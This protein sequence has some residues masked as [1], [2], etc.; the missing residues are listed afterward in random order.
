MIYLDQLKDF[1]VYKKPFL[2]PKGTNK[3]KKKGNSVFL[4]TPSIDSSIGLINHPL[5]KDNKYYNGYYIEKDV[6]FFINNESKCFEY[7]PKSTLYIHECLK[8]NALS[9]INE[10]GNFIKSEE[11]IIFAGNPQDIQDIKQYISLDKMKEMINNK[12]LG[13]T[14]PIRISIEVQ[15]SDDIS[16]ELGINNNDSSFICEPVRSLSEDYREKYY[17]LIMANIIIQLL[18][19]K[20]NI[21]T[22]EMLTYYIAGEDCSHYNNYSDFVQQISSKSNQLELMKFL[23]EDLR[24]L[25]TESFIVQEEENPFT[26]IRRN[27]TNSI[28]KGGIRKLDSTTSDIEVATKLG[29]TNSSNIDNSI[30]TSTPEDI[31]N[32]IKT[33]TPDMPKPTVS[34]SESF[35]NDKFVREDVIIEEDMIKVGEIITYFNEA[36]SEETNPK[37]YKMLYK[38]RIRTNKELFQYYHYIKD[39]C[40]KIDKTYVNYVRYKQFNIYIDLFYYNQLFFKNNI[41]KLDKGVELYRAFL[42]KAMHNTNYIQS[43]YEK[44]QKTVLVPV[45]DWVDNL[46]TKMYIYTHDINPISMI[47]RLLQNDPDMVRDLFG[48][49]NVVF[50]T[51]SCYFKVNFSNLGGTDYPT[52]IAALKRLYASTPDQIVDDTPDSKEAIVDKIIDDIENSQQVKISYLTGKG[53]KTPPKEVQIA[54]QTQ[55]KEKIKQ[56]EADKEAIVDKIEKAA[57]NAVDVDQAIDKL[58]ED[59]EFKKLLIQLADEEQNGVIMNSSRATRMSNLNDEFLNKELNGRTVKDILATR[60]KYNSEQIEPISLPID[61]INPEWQELYY[62]NMNN[63]YDPEVDIVAALR[64]LS[65]KSYPVSIRNIEVEDTSTSE[66]YVYTYTVEMENHQGKRFKLRFDIPKLVNNQYMKLKGNKKVISSQSFLMPILKTDEDTAQIVTNYNKIFIYRY[67]MQPGKSNPATDRLL[68]AISKGP[69]KGITVKKGNNVSICSRYE[70]PIDYIDIGGLYDSFETNEVIFMFNYSDLIKMAEDKKLKIDYNKGFPCGFQK[71]NNYEIIYFKPQ[72]NYK[73]LSHFIARVLR[74]ASQEFNE[75]FMKT[76]QGTKCCY[77]QASIL[78]SKIPVILLL[79]YVNGLTK[80]L[81]LAGIKYNFVEKKNREKEAELECGYIQFADGYLEYEETPQASLLLNGL[82]DRCDTAFYSVSDMNK[83]STFLELLDNFME[84][85]KSDGLDNFNDCL[86]DP[87]TNDVC[88]YYKLPA[89]YSSMLIYGSNLLVDNK[90]IKHGSQTGRRL[91]RNELIAAYFYKALSSAYGTY[92]SSVR[93]GREAIITM[94]QSAVVDLIMADPTSQDLSIINALNEK[95]SYDAVTPK[96]LSGM[97]SDRSYSLD[98]RA[99][100]D[101]MINVLGMSTGFASTVGINRQATINASVETVRGY[102]K[103]SSIDQMNSVNSLCMSEAVTPMGTTRDDPFRSAM[104][105]VQ[106]TR[107]GM[108]VRHADPLLVTNGGDKAL[109]YLISDIFA[110]KAKDDGE[111]VEFVEDS[112]MIIRYKS[113]DCDFV[114]LSSKVEKNSSNGFYVILKL[115][116]DYKIGDKVKKGHIIAYDRAS[117]NPNTG[118]DNDLAYKVATLASVAL[119]DTDEGFEDSAIISNTL[120]EAMASDIS[121]QKVI[122][123]D[124]NTNIYNVLPA[125]SK[126]QEGQILMQ[127]QRPYDEEDANALLKI[128]AAEEE[129]VSQLGRI[130]ISS[131]VTGEISD[132]SILRSCELDEMSES[133]RAFCKKIEGKNKTKRADMKKYGIKKEYELEPDYKLPATGKLKDCPDGVKIIFTLTYHDKMSV[134]DKLIYYSA[135]KGVTKDVFPIGDEPYIYGHPERLIHALVSIAATNGRMVTSIQNNGCLGRLLVEA[136]WHCQEMAGIPVDYSV[137]SMDDLDS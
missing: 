115:D 21:D 136:G 90:Y 86:V 25:Y 1:H 10:A 73:Y 99:F 53:D 14:V 59:E 4:L 76:K 129:E 70:L 58:E 104:T 78:S 85:I 116:T 112:H 54:N 7:D 34:E 61:S 134:G 38:E 60:E 80:S 27:I 51:E 82:R 13:I 11:E 64:S 19:L 33:A 26:S 2:F 74:T 93:H 48:D 106:T 9:Y 39:K 107:H 124:K 119:I 84:R 49:A 101:S 137:P 8:G 17:N 126:V 50:M 81:D 105:F 96:G 79:G 41:Y 100:D 45:K 56:V 114:D 91:R 65:T 22:M 29:K 88:D 111:V 5:L 24:T 66:D 28:R 127:I 123:L 98:K 131:P 55:N 92:A 57:D 120:S 108:R 69:F 77:A 121:E 42:Y 68:K 18:K 118:I 103:P 125:G 132:I 31:I 109:P 135:N 35:Y 36:K 95:E 32:Q 12:L 117:F 97:N 72:G 46:A 15:S 3:D 20:S 75:V 37:L 89:D 102:I 62:A 94:K 16:Y 71:S 130:A 113:G 87:I 6:S 52:F 128:L 110:F 122:T 40:L 63:S 44:G 43:G 47:T 83:K 67:G 133:L 30:H 23:K